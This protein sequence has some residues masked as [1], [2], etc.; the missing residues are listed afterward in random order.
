MLLRQIFEAENKI[1]SFA[2][3]RLNPAT[4]GHEL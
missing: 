3:G 4:I 1:A 2:I